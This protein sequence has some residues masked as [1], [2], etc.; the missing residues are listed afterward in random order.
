MSKTGLELDT[1]NLPMQAF[2]AWNTAGIILN[3]LAKI[4]GPGPWKDE[5]KASILEAY[6]DM[7]DSGNASELGI[8]KVAAEKSARAVIES[9]FDRVAFAD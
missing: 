7:S 8:D 1:D 4:R 6:T 5:L 2:A 9:I 3:E